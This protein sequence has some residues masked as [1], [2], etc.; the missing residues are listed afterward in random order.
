M[1]ISE[2]LGRSQWEDGAKRG[3]LSMRLTFDLGEVRVLPGGSARFPCRLWNDS[4]RRLTYQFLLEPQDAFRPA[5]WRAYGPPS[6]EAG[7]VA[8]ISLEVVIPKEGVARLV[9]RHRLRLVVIPD[10][11]SPRTSS[12]CVL[13]VES[14]PCVALPSAPKF[15]F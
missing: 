7:Q 9:G 3:G 6:L 1:I 11:I 2:T 12:E 10:E 15:H 8:Q 4:G 5:S 13:V 14:E